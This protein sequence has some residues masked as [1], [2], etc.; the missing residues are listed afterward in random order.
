MFA[1]HWTTSVG[2]GCSSRATSN[3]DVTPFCTLQTKSAKLPYRTRT[4]ELHQPWR[5]SGYSSLSAVRPH[6]APTAR[7]VTPAAE[8]LQSEGVIKTELV[9]LGILA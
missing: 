8:Q 4:D 7:F 1:G 9:W 3:G 2:Y 5:T 6:A